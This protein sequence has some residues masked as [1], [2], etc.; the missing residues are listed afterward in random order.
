MEQVLQSG[1]MFIRLSLITTSSVQ[2]LI[3][4]SSSPP[5][6]DPGGAMAAEDDSGC[7]SAVGG[8]KVTPYLPATS[9]TICR[10]NM[11]KN[12]ARTPNDGMK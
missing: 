3:F 4:E 1:P 7:K 6:V 12:V 11:T 10:K 2:E 8:S 9:F 5:A